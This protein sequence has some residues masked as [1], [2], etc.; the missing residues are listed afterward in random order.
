M[1]RRVKLLVY[2]YAINIATAGTHSFLFLHCS[3]LCMVS[4][5]LYVSLCLSYLVHV[6]TNHNNLLELTAN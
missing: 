2:I 1:Y 4:Y 6:F 3:I 5:I